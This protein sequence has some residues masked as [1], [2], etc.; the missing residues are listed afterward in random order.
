MSVKGMACLG[1]GRAPGLKLHL[2]DREIVRKRSVIAVGG[3]RGDLPAFLYPI[4]PLSDTP[5]WLSQMPLTVTFDTN[6]FDKVSRPALYSKDQGHAE[7]VKVHDA[8]KRGD[9]QGFICDAALTLEGI[10]G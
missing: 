7:M 4:M 5:G 10:G 2:V 1:R 6:T 3:I 9:I 8:L